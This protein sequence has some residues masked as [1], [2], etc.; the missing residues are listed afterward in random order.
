MSNKAELKPCPFC[1][2]EA[3]T[4]TSFS[5]HGTVSAIVCHKCGA[6]IRRPFDNKSAVTKLWN[7]RA[8]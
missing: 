7:T 6:A 5:D 1:G 3:K 4:S 8:A 2:G